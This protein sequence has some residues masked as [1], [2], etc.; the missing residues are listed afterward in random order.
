MINKIIS[1][2]CSICS[3]FLFLICAEIELRIYLTV[4]KCPATESSLALSCYVLFNLYE[5]LP[6]QQRWR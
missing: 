3:F 2:S 1:I 6:P 4:G 5:A